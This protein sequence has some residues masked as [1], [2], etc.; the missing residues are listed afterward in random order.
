MR[1]DSGHRVMERRT[2]L[3]TIAGGLLAAP[4]AAQAQQAGKVYRIGW[5][6]LSAPTSAPL[7]RPSESFL[8]GL[9]DHGFAEG[10]NV[11][12]ERRYSEGR[13]DRHTAFAAELVQMKVDLIVAGSSAAAH[14]AKQATSTIPI[15]M[16]AVAD[17]ERQGLVVSLARPGGNLTGIS[18][19]VGGEAAGK[20]FQVLKET[21][22]KLSKLGIIWNPDN[23]SLRR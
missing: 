15:V 14:A 21:V 6:G 7:Q 3:G 4:L 1:V 12:I 18:N 17:P 23:Q 9:R 2:F 20:V 13:E 22:P 8:Q 11:I 19:Q 10:Q 5:L 16:V